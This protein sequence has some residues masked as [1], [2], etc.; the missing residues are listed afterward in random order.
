MV[1]H[2]KLV[3]S[4]KRFPTKII[5]AEVVISLITGL[6][7]LQTYY[8]VLEFVE[9]QITFTHPDSIKFKTNI[10]PCSYDDEN[11]KDEGYKDT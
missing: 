4:G 11:N 10:L 6:G 7:I 9:L 8:G 2:V 1:K 3:I 5:G